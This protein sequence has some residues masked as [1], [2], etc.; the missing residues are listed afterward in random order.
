MKHLVVIPTYK[1]EEN[2]EK[3][4]IEI[5]NLY[6]GISILVVDDASPDKTAEIVIA[7]QK[8][9]PNL[10][11]MNRSGKLGLAS[12]YVQGFKWGLEK[13]F[14]LFTT[15]DADFS[16]KPCHIQT[17]I[18]KINEGYDV[19]CGSRYIKDGNTTEKHWFR[20]FISIGGNAWVNFVLGT[21]IKD[22][23]EGFSTFTKESLKK[24]NLDAIL[25]R[26][27][28][29]GAE[30]KYRATKKG[31]KVVEFPI[32]FEERK[33][34]KSKMSFDIISEAFFHV[35]RIRFSK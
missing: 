34:G 26:G 20:N 22:I 29:F 15:C 2:I 12:A 19:A 11:L 30:M 13:G 31:C 8:K 1:E 14:D 28:I 25:A 5:F 21:N 27:F 4:I 16:H 9:Y 10:F 24:I 17:A 35:I 6:E 32:L 23:L 33:A 18:D 7:L 3:I